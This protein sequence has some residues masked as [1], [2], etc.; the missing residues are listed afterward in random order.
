VR[1]D[2]HPYSRG[3][4]YELSRLFGTAGIR[5]AN[6]RPP[7]AYD[8]RHTFAVQRLTL[9]YRSGV[10]LHARLPWLSAYLGHDDLFGTETYLR[11]TP[12]L[13]AEAGRRLEERVSRA[14][15]AP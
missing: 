5:A 15:R 7:R 14:R 8:L 10:D 13:L 3:L 4:L 2:G 9:W 11:A 12:E 6:G 1:A